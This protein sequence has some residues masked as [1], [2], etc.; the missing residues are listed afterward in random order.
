MDADKLLASL[1]HPTSGGNGGTAEQNGRSKKK[2]KT[3]K[4]VE[5]V[6]KTAALKNP[7]QV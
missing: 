2:R 7:V 4:D 3:L 1:V 6:G 5:A